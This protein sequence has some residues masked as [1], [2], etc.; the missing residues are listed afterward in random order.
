ME[1]ERRR[2]ISFEKG[3]RKKVKSMHTPDIDLEMVFRFKVVECRVGGN[4]IFYIK[5]TT[6][7]SMIS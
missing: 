3:S 5:K 2:L 1:V 4:Y 7:Q 6:L